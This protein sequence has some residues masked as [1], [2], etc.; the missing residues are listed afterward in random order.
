MHLPDYR[1]CVRVAHP[2]GTIP[3][4]SARTVA[5]AS[6]TPSVAKLVHESQH[7]WGRPRAEV[8]LA[9]SDIWEGRT[10]G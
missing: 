1:F 3:A 9:L 8:K 2:V 6:G 4:F 7:R 5:L 10:A